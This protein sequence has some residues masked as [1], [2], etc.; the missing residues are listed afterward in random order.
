MKV[1]HKIR[2]QMLLGRRFTN[3]LVYALGEII[4]VVLGILIALYLNNWSKEKQLIEYNL[5]LQQRVLEQLDEDIEDLYVFQNELDSL[6]NVYLRVLG[7]KYDNT[8]IEE[9]G[10]ITTILFDVKDLGL[11]KQNINWIDNANLDNSKAS[12]SLIRLSSIYKLYFKN[13][14]DIEIIIYKKLTSNLELLEKTKPWY[15]KLITDFECQNECINYLLKDEEHKARIASLR[16]L[17]INSYGD[18]VQGF[19][20]DLIRQ[21]KQLERLMKE[22]KTN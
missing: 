16:F 21:K 13:I 7:R 5:N 19:Y 1:F 14:D 3:Y 17:Y 18:L 6:N 12:E 15:T 11:N 10:I 22:A 4:L 9:G 20:H 2:K 8:K